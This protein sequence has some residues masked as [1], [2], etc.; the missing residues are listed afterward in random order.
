MWYMFRWALLI[1][2][3]VKDNPAE[4]NCQKNKGIHTIKAATKMAKAT[5]PDKYFPI[6]GTYPK[7]EVKRKKMHRSTMCPVDDPDCRNHAL[8]SFSKV[9]SPSFYWFLETHAIY[10]LLFIYPNYLTYTDLYILIASF[11]VIPV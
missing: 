3:W 1:Q 9:P 11:I 10:C 4:P 5:A 6:S 2:L 8:G 7:I